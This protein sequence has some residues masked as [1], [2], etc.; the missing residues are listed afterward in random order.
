MMERIEVVK[1]PVK[2]LVVDDREDN[3]LSIETIFENS[4]YTICTANSGRAALRALLKSDDFTLILMDVQMPD[5]S[6]FETA[7][8]IYER[9]KLKHIPIIF[10]TANDHGDENIFRGYQMGGVDYIY[11]PVNPDLL[12][13]KVDVF[14]ELYQKNHQLIAQ[15][16]KMAAANARLEKEIGERIKSEEKINQL[17]RQLMK[18]IA[19]LKASNEEL[20]RFAYVASHDLQEPLRKIILFSDQLSVKYGPVLN[21]EGRGF[22]ERIMK[23]TERMRMLIKNILNFSKSTSDN[24]SFEETDLNVLLDGI[25]SDLEVSIQQKS[26]TI[27]IQRLPVLKVVPGQFRQLFQNLLINALKFSKENTPPEI[28]IYAEKSKGMKLEGIIPGKYDDYFFNI[29]IKDNGI[30][31][32]QKYASEIFTLFKRLNS[33]DKFEGTGIGLSICK[34]IVE[35]H[36]GFISATSEPGQ[37]TTFIISLPVKE[38]KDVK[39]IARNI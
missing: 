36:N 7:T 26:A 13:A 10:I 22:I 39:L 27:K 21:D 15:E 31:F 5:L 38:M 2:I 3:L 12:R 8:L 35:H 34:K 19:W 16:Q 9:D 37:G 23:A 28:T 25:L 33:Y 24:E 18:N 1:S 32:E 30:G 11:K 29:Y 4:G 6:G 17:N 14:V 20:E